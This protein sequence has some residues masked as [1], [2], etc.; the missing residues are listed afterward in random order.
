[1]LQRRLP[2]RVFVHD[3]LNSALYIPAAAIIENRMRD[4]HHKIGELGA[5]V[6]AERPEFQLINYTYDFF[7]LHNSL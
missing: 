6:T 1:M 2:E 7:I 3:A 5:H 4:E